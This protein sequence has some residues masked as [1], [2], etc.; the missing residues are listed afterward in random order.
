MIGLR[1]PKSFKRSGHFRT[2][3]GKHIALHVPHHAGIKYYNYK[4]FHGIV[5]MALIDADYEFIYIDVSWNGRISDGGIKSQIN[6]IVKSRI[7]CITPKP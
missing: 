7:I 3:D 5:L 6:L 4:N 2:L 1:S